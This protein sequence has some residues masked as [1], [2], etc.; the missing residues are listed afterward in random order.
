MY[1]S[2]ASKTSQTQKKSIA[3][4]GKKRTQKSQREENES[5]ASSDRDNSPVRIDEF[6]ES[7]KESKPEAPM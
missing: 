2:N 5:T 4:R 6:E 3:R 7:S 1:L